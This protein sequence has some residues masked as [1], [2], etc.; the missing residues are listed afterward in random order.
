MSRAEWLST[1][2]GRTL[3]F[4]GHTLAAGFQ[5]AVANVRD[6]SSR[7]VPNRWRPAFS[8]D[9]E[10]MIGAGHRMNYASF[11]DQS[12]ARHPDTIAL[13]DGERELSFREFGRET[14]RVAGALERLGL[15]PNDAI[16]VLSENRFEHLILMIAA[17]RRGLIFAPVHHG[18]RKREL[19]YVLRNCTPKAVFVEP[20]L[21]GLLKTSE[22]ET[23]FQPDHLVVFE[24]AEKGAISY[25]QFL[26]GAEPAETI[27][28]EATHPLLLFYTS[29]TSSM[30]KPV[31]RSH[32]TERWSAENYVTGWNFEAGDKVLIAL[33]LA[34]A[35]GIQCQAQPCLAVGATMRILPRFNPVQVLET[36]E[37]DRITTFAGALSMYPLLLDV[38]DKQDYDVSSLRKIFGGAEPRNET[39]IAKTQ[40][41]FGQRLCEAYALSESSPVFAVKPSSKIDFPTLTVGLAVSPDIE[42]R[43]VDED[44]KDVKP[45]EPGDLLLRSPGNM[46]GY[47]R[48]PELTAERMSP[49]GW[50]N[51]GDLLRRSEDG[52]FFFAG[53]RTDLIIR[54]GTNI[55]PL[56]IEEALIEHE[57]VRD[58][59]VAG[60][61][62]DVKGQD[63]VAGVVLRKGV[64]LSAEDLGDYLR[65]RVSSY[66]IPQKIIFLD[67]VPVGTTGK[68]N[69][70][71]L[72]GIVNAT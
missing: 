20:A 57:G 56:E 42:I 39:I 5:E 3:E 27:E 21:L 14:E 11:V 17:A 40:A 24:N 2:H 26:D 12:I 7:S 71:A 15:Q 8:H 35:Y 44:G 59:V 23:G 16:L 37:S 30:P 33:S 19:G 38:L 28:V 65:S 13:S 51:T 54:G 45:G 72:V 36:I 34:W 9:V 62:N 63:I 66:K 49:E 60:I 31:I 22:A 53:R 25:S 29:G 68:K 6:A 1:P 70:Q 10:P 58:A 67:E 55:S 43:L 47:Y 64:T 46:L 18:F 48:E 61:P 32:R 69:R 4:G 50:I 52:F 41:R